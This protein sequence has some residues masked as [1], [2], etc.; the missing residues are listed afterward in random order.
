MRVGVWEVTSGESA[1]FSSVHA[2]FLSAP[3]LLFGNILGFGESSR[4]LR[5]FC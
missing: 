2:A 3:P 5:H 4:V 1:S